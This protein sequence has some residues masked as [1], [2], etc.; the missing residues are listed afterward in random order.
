ML[1][2]LSIFIVIV[3]VLFLLERKREVDGQ[4]NPV[5]RIWGLGV[6]L[7]GF[8]CVPGW[9][10][11]VALSGPAG[12]PEDVLTSAVLSMLSL[13]AG[14]FSFYYRITLF[15]DRIE[16]RYLPFLTNK[17]P[18]RDMLPSSMN[19]NDC[20]H[21]RFSNGRKIDIV[22]FFSGRRHF[23]GALRDQ[24]FISRYHSNES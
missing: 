20:G 16:V 14:A 11:I 19:K 21:F 13:A 22:A 8:A 10:V 6:L 18:L 12:M 17:Y 15:G 23:I 3:G 1:K 2:Q 5:M 9:D 4:G 7:V 24:K